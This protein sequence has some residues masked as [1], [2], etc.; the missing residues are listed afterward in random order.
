MKQHVIAHDSMIARD[1][2]RQSDILEDLQIQTKKA[3]NSQRQQE[4]DGDGP[5]IARYGRRQQ[6]KAR[7]SQK[8]ELFLLLP[9]LGSKNF[10]C[11][12]FLILTKELEIN[13]KNMIELFQQAIRKWNQIIGNGIIFSTYRPLINKTSFVIVSYFK[14]RAQNGFSKQ[15]IELCKHYITHFNGS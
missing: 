8:M 10:F 4:I 6:Q 7:D 15:E 5:V 2:P 1:S 14:Q 11:K 3:P 12:M 13:Y 9:G